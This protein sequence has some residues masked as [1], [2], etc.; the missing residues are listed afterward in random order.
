MSRTKF[1][2]QFKQAGT[3]ILNGLEEYKYNGDRG[4]CIPYQ[5]ESAPRSALESARTT[6]TS[7][8]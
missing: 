5:I 1:T 3:Q 2:Q 7:A 4:F 6:E 8:F